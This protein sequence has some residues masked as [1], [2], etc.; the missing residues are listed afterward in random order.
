MLRGFEMLTEELDHPEGVAWDPGGT[1]Y[2]G[3]EAGQI[4]AISLEGEVRE[5]A[6]TGGE[7]LGVAVD[8][9]GRVYACD[10]GN[11]AVMR[12]D[13]ATGS[14]E[15]YSTGTSGMP[16]RLPNA[17]A[18]DGAGN[19]YVTDSGEYLQDD[20]VIFRVSRSGQ[21]SVWTGEARRY[22]NG[23][24]LT[25]DG[26]GLLVVESYRP[27]VVR[28][29]ILPDGSAGA[30]EM[31]IGLPGTVPDGIALDVAGRLYITCY[32]PDRLY[33][34][35]P[36]GDAELL[37]DDPHGAYLNAPTNI[38]FVGEGLDRMVVANVGEWHLLIGEPGPRGLA[39]RHPVPA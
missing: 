13:P 31:V 22:P 2:A 26:T 34:V 17:L 36:G 8:G 10:P 39:L 4:Y 32:R 18:F 5:V 20:G 25:A 3:G 33:V 23:C 28:I 21:T 19:L 14:V 35:E 9:L 16:M 11:N 7:I 29:P 12:I 37:A 30:L 15:T 38:A 6:S 1:V 27:G 24:C